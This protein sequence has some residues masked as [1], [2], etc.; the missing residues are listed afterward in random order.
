L[1]GAL[2]T[3]S[4]ANLNNGYFGD[5]NDDLNH[6]VGDM[7]LPCRS[8]GIRLT[9]FHTLFFVFVDAP[10]PRLFFKLS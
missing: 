9:R 4:P 2:A 3:L 7:N 1:K 8:T 6:Q 5:I 10:T